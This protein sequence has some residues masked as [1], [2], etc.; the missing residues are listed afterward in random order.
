MKSIHLPF[1]FQ[2]WNWPCA[3]DTPALVHLMLGL[4][5]N[6]ISSVSHLASYRYF[7]SWTL[8]MSQRNETMSSILKTV[9]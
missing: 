1:Y 8:E 2:L 3:H 5:T 6:A 9:N 4:Q 7:Q